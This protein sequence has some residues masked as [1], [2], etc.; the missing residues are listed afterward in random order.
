MPEEVTETVEAQE[1]LDL[2]TDLPEQESFDRDY[3][4]KLRA[5]AAARRTEAKAL[6]DRYDIFESGYDDTE[7]DI[8][9]GIARRFA[10]EQ[11]PNIFI[12][13]ARA[14]GATIPEAQEETQTVDTEQIEE[15]GPLTPEKV[16]EI[17]AAALA[18]EREAQTKSQAEK[19]SLSAF[20]AQVKEAG[21]ENGSPEYYSIMAKVAKGTKVEDAIKD[22]TDWRQGIIDA[23][24]EGRKND[25]GV[26][27]PGN[28][29][30]GGKPAEKYKSIEEATAALAKEL[31]G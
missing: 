24:I 18:A 11:D 5:E 30:A 2:D 15:A 12:E 14:L 13:V 19:E 10:A 21:F 8:W 16:Q 31:A 25:T 9:A 1:E 27:S 29:P 22:T 3:V 4:S 20:E 7:R 6:K 26:R 28:G 17:V 23:Y